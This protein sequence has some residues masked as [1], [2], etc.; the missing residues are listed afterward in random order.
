MTIEKRA[1]AAGIDVH[2]DPEECELFMRLASDAEKVNAGG[3]EPGVYKNA[4]PSYFAL[5]LALGRQIRALAAQ[6]SASS[7]RESDPRPL[8]RAMVD[9]ILGSEPA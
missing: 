9:L 5:S 3:L 1:E 4:D 8:A 7:R 6:E 2:L